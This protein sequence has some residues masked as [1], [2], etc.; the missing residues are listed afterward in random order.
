MA[1]SRRPAPREPR[2]TWAPPRTWWAP[3][4]D[5][6]PSPGRC[7]QRLSSWGRRGRRVGACRGPELLTRRLVGRSGQC[8]HLP[9]VVVGDRAAV[10]QQLAVVVEE[11][12]AVAQQ[13]P[14]LLGVAGQHGGEIAG[15]AVGGRARGGVRAHGCLLEGAG[16]R[17]A[18]V[19]SRE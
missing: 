5:G 3:P 15:V 12:D 11:D 17:S 2:T 14:P 16:L 8:C 7:C 13:P 19:P 9:R 18:I 1:G 10:G 4:P 6:V